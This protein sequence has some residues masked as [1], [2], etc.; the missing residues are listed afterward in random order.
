MKSQV[1]TG[2]ISMAAINNRAQSCV[3]SR[4]RLS[5]AYRN[6]IAARAIPWFALLQL[7]AVC[8][9]APMVAPVSPLSVMQTFATRSV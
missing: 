2:A 5:V 9:D 1:M 3:D 6:A 8:S 4:H 7:T